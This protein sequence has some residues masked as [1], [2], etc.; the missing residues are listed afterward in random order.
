MRIDRLTVQ[1]F[2][3]FE[4]REFRFHPQ[5]NLLAG[6]NGTGKTTVLDALAVAA[7]GWFLGLKGCD[8][9]HIRGA[10]VRLQAQ[11]P[12][13]AGRGRTST[14]VRWES[15]FPCSVEASGEILGRKLTWIRSL[16]SPK[17]RTTHG[18]AGEIK[19]LSARTDAEIRAGTAGTLPLV[20]YYG[21]GRLWDA[22]R[23]RSQ[24]RSERQLLGRETLSR[25]EGYRN[26]VDPRISTS[27]LIR[28]IARQSWIAY[29]QRGQT[30]LAFRTVKRAI[31][32]CLTEGR[33]LYFDPRRG[34]VIVEIGRQGAQPFDNLSDGQRAV[35]AMVGDMACKAAM[36]NP[37]LQGRILVAT[38]GVVL[39]DELDLHL[40][41]VWQRRVI[42]DLRKVFPRIQFFAT[43]HSPFLIQSLRSGEELLQLEGAPTAQLA[44]KTL[45]DIAH[46]I[47]G[48]SLPA[49]SER[50]TE[51]KE[52]AFHYLAELEKQKR[53][54]KE[55]LAEF[56]KRL[57]QAAAPYADNPAFQAFLEMKLAA[58]SGD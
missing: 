57:A 23:E 44:N 19:A 43:T 32:G 14:E 42:E 33:D 37:H 6:E 39:I 49:V 15:Q 28:W 12:L 4:R 58:K 2:K 30:S 7:A 41:P 27:G 3:G 35:L 11:E 56:Q 24:V 8:S 26:S 34:E 10:E 48:V 21:T 22:P 53:L 16:N 5:V 47:M 36:L 18:G 51:M 45:A 9:R 1:N 52:T 54:P 40:H 46:G 20:S 31:L 38:P 17:G 13:Q 29:Q 50:Y 55:K 25:L